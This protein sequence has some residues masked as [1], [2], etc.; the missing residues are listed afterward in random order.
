MPAVSIEMRTHA[1][2]PHLRLSFLVFWDTAPN[3]GRSTITQEF[4]KL[5]T[6]APLLAFLD[7]AG[8][9]WGREERFTCSAMLPL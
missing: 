4:L 2:V 3:L 8:P 6:P 1:R 9:G 7:S 5:P